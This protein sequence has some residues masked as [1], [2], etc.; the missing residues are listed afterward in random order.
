MSVEGSAKDLESPPP[1]K[2][3][4]TFEETHEV[5][6]ATSS[7][8]KEPPI[9]KQPKTNVSA[10]EKGSG[11]RPPEQEETEPWSFRLVLNLL[12]LISYCA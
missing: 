2:N 9:T 8:K 7:D 11:Y 5:A 4:S 6:R 10:K 12:Y 1:S 3:Y